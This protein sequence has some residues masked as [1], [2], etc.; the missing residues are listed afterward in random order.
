M[1]LHKFGRLLCVN[2]GAIQSLGRSSSFDGTLLSFAS[3]IECTQDGD[4]E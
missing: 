2:V 1:F 4:A 3:I